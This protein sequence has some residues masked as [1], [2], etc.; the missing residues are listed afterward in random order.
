MCSYNELENN[1]LNLFNE[2]V[3]RFFI[4]IDKYLKQTK[5]REEIDKLNHN[6]I[7]EQKK[8]KSHENEID[9]LKKKLAAVQVS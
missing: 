9:T 6:L 3:F 2:N 5:L 1:K 4:K 8:T 7:E